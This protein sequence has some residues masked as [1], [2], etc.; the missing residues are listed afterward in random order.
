MKGYDFGDA[1]EP[2]RR[3][4]GPV[5]FVPSMTLT[6]EQAAALGI[7]GADDLF[8]GVV[9]HAFV[10]TKAISHPLVAPD[11]AALPGWNPS[12]AARV[13][14]AVLAGYT[15]FNLD[16]A[17]RA[18]LRLLASGPVRIKPVR[19]TGGHGQSVARDATQLQGLLDGIDPAEVLSHGLVIEEDLT[20]VRT[21]SVGQ[22]RVAGLSASYFGIQHLTR[23]NRGDEVFGEGPEPPPHAI[24]H[25]RGTDPRVGRLTKY[26]LVEPYGDA[27]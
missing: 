9:P 26:T 5:Y 22:V 13:G 2:S 4:S 6:C 7:R 8:G 19:A 25:F 12:F 1:Y 10:A 21:F 20:E 27:R 11:A 23:K 16:D 15:A 17:R 3:Y 14:D 24:V 18:G